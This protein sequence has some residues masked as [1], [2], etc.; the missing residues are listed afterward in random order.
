M[1]ITSGDWIKDFETDPGGLVAVHPS[2]FLGNNYPSSFKFKGDAR[3]GSTSPLPFKPWIDNFQEYSM[4]QRSLGNKP[5]SLRSLKHAKISSSDWIQDFK[6]ESVNMG[7][8]DPSLFVAAYRDAIREQPTATSSPPSIMS[9]TH[10]ACHPPSSAPKPFL[11]KPTDPPSAASVTNTNTPLSA[12][13]A[14]KK[15]KKKN[16]KRMLDETTVVEPNEG[17]VLSGRGGFTNTHP[18]NVRFRQKAL[19]FRPWYEE[20]SKEK[21]Q[22]I[23]SLL[24]DFVKNE[25]NRFLGK[26]KD[27]QWHEMIGKGPHYKASQALRERI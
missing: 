15:K 16:R 27:G 22:E 19:E 23:A 25:G 12:S 5:P 24:V 13:A 14:P 1:G 18:G 10:L 17:D 20:S 9:A 8:M 7:P 11:N 6:E 4:S 2:L 26:G 3:E 21:K